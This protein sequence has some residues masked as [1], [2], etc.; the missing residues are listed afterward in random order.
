MAIMQTPWTSQ[1]QQAV[2]IDLS[3]Q[4]ATGLAGVFNAASGRV[5]EAGGSVFSLLAGTP[6]STT[7]QIGKATTIWRGRSRAFAPASQVEAVFAVFK[8][9]SS[10]VDGAICTATNGS[11]GCSLSVNAGVLRFSP[12][13]NSSAY[14]DFSTPLVDGQVYTALA[15]STGPASNQRFCYLNG[16][17]DT[18]TTS[19]SAISAQAALFFSIGERANAVDARASCDIVVCAAWKGQLF[20]D[21]KVK[22]LTQNPW[23]IFKPLP[24]RIFVPVAS[25]DPTLY[26]SLYNNTNTFYDP[27]V[28]VGAVT[29]T[30]S[31]F[32]N[33]NTFH[34]ATVTL[35]GA[36]QTLTPSLYSNTNTFYGPSVGPGAV[37]LTPALFS[38]TNSFFGA[39]VTLDT[40]KIL[41]PSLVSNSNSFYGP[42][43]SVGAVS[44]FPSLL[45]NSNTFYNH[46]VGGA[47]TD[48]EK[49][50]LILD[51]LS[52]RQTLDA[53]TGIYT[54]YADDGVTVLKT[55]RA[56]EDAE[57]TQ[58]YRGR[59]LK[60]LDALQ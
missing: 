4:F 6:T 48:S 34:A 51:I 14:T 59:S 57:G 45:V 20:N 58:P 28:S 42:T 31:L 39:V 25:G 16:V 55:A 5:N 3:N 10:A 60:R 37:T 49:L 19:G 54:L 56:W 11:Y 13:T 30:P 2:G 27:T 22:S 46:V 50:D 18:G 7:L 38:N 24:R 47:L 29:L 9:N 15:F 52:N 17:L 43:V 40:D 12:S 33:S 21:S 41:Y 44:I 8:V 32:S 53:T 36:T 26:P 1:P 35:G 23:Q